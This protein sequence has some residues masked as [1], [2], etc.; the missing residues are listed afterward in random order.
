M[1]N[2]LLK[3]TNGLRMILGVPDYQQY[4][5]HMQKNHPDQ[6]MFTEIEYLVNRQNSKFDGASRGCC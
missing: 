5:Q 1:N 4:K 3:I 2:K 6:I